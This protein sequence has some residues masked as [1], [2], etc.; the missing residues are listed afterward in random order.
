M[1]SPLVV[2]YYKNIFLGRYLRRGCRFMAC[3]SGSGWGFGGR[4]SAHTLSK[5]EQ[6]FA[7]YVKIYDYT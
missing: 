1:I 5:Y 2:L 3:N 6:T 4:F 7:K